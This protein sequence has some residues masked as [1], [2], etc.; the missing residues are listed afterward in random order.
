MK[1]FLIISGIFSYIAI[2]SVVYAWM[3]H[4]DDDLDA[5]GQAIFWPIFLGFLAV[6][7]VVSFPAWLG[8]KLRNWYKEREEGHHD[9]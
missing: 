9:R 2:A 8:V 7:A 5:L 4:E 6:A 1:V 3:A